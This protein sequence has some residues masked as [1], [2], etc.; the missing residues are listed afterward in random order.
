MSYDYLEAYLAGELEAKAFYQQLF[1][2]KDLQT[3]IR[4]LI[5]KDAMGNPEHPLWKRF[6]YTALSR[7]HFDLFRYVEN[8]YRFDGSLGDNLNIWG[9]ISDFYQY[10]HPDFTITTKYHDAFDLFLNA[11]GDTFSGPEVQAFVE[12]IIYEELNVKPKTKRIKETRARIREAFHVNDGPKPYWIQGGEWPMGKNT[13]MRF[14]RKKR[15]GEKV[16]YYFEDTETGE[17]R[18]ITQYY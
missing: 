13:P 17:M 2:N 1:S 14:M 4:E 3:R 7:Y 9:T 8:A 18:I 5:P 16:E 6:A 12:R 11:A 15:I 10:H